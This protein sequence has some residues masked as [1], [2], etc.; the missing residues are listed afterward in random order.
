MKLSNLRSA[1]QSIVTSE[2]S[3]VFLVQQSFGLSRRNGCNYGPDSREREDKATTSKVEDGHRSSFIT[4]YFGIQ[5]WDENT[6]L[7]LCANSGSDGAVKM[8][9]NWKGTFRCGF[10]CGLTLSPVLP[11][12]TLLCS[13]T[14]FSP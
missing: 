10:F 14:R 4:S 13:C 2:A 9:Q 12:S 5:T 11:Q 3:L 6:R 8:L 7:K 1:G